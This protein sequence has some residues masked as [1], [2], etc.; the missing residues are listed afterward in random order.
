MPL[1]P[2]HFRP[3]QNLTTGLTHQLHDNGDNA[4]FDP[5]GGV[6]TAADILRDD[7]RDMFYMVRQ[8]QPVHGRR[9]RISYYT[10]TLQPCNVICAFHRLPASRYDN[11]TPATIASDIHGYLRMT[12]LDTEKLV[13]PS[14]P[15]V[16]INDRITALDRN[17]GTTTYR[18]TAL[19]R[20]SP[21]VTIYHLEKDLR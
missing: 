1:S 17:G 14:M 20:Q 18:I 2:R 10:A 15:G 11:P 9:G 16:R 6:P 21:G 12:G 5:R 7:N 4:L 13:T 3:V 19:D 8:V